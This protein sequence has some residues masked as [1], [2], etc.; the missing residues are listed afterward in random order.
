V[1]HTS[2]AQHLPRYAVSSI[3]DAAEFEAAVSPYLRSG[4]GIA[5]VRQLGDQVVAYWGPK[6]EWGKSPL[7]MHTPSLHGGISI[8]MHHSAMAMLGDSQIRDKVYYIADS[9]TFATPRASGPIEICE[10]AKH[11]RAEGMKQWTPEGDID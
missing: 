10:E 4:C 5:I 7:N 6:A 2:Y 11:M 1:V 9:R 8:F 3:S